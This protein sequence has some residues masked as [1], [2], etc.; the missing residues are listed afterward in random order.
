VIRSNSSDT[1]NALL[2][3]LENLEVVEINCDYWEIPSLKLRPNVKDLRVNCKSDHKFSAEQF[4][5]VFPDLEVLQI[6]SC[7]FEVTESSFTT[8]LSGLK[9]LKTLNLDS[10]N[11]ANLDSE[12][13]LQCFQVHGKH[14][15]EI[16]VNAFE[17]RSEDDNYIIGFTIKKEP[18]DC[19]RVIQICD[20]DYDDIYWDSDF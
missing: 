4:T 1:V 17:S 14:L 3:Q 19:I 5:K 8:L 7:H 10:T 15:E 13:I 6:S 12:L 11:N 2:D 18:N 20:E 16:E 9:Q